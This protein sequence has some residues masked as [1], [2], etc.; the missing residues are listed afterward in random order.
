[1]AVLDSY[2]GCTH[3]DIT[4]VF[5]KRMGLHAPRFT[6]VSFHV[7]SDYSTSPHYYLVGLLPLEKNHTTFTDGK[8]HERQQV[9]ILCRWMH[10]F[11]FDG[12]LGSGYG[13]GGEEQAGRGCIRFIMA[14]NKNYWTKEPGSS[15]I[16]IILHYNAIGFH[17]SSKIGQNPKNRLW[18]TVG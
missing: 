1:M 9:H 3:H 11:C 14:R 18:S 5:V 12:W 16:W 2:L 17:L 8:D 15:F 10:L 7:R 6:R 13:G 4:C